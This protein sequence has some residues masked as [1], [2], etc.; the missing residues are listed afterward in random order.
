MHLEICLT[1]SR[2]CTFDDENRRVTDGDLSADDGRIV[3]R[4]HIEVTAV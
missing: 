3:D 1:C 4:D 2:I